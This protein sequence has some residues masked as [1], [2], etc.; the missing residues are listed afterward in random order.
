MLGESAW[1][2]V[3]S[4]HISHPVCEEEINRLLHCLEKLHSGGGQQD[5]IYVISPF[6][7]VAQACRQ[8]VGKPGL[9][10][11]VECGTVHT[12]QGKEAEI[13]FLVLG[14]APGQAGAGARSWAAS[15]PNLL[16]VAVTR[17]KCRFFVIGDASQWQ[18]L[19]Y[20][21]TLHGRPA[22]A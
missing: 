21:R 13:V 3:R 8:T 12:F 11:I 7:K 16:N 10:D 2:D 9:G 5:K 20:F 6:R 17:A 14:T 1:C 4:S 15:K 18:A 22:H 19:D